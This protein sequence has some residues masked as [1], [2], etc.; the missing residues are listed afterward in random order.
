MS[1]RSPFAG[2]KMTAPLLSLSD[3]SVGYDGTPVASGVS[4]EV[5]A[6]EFV[7]LLGPSGCGK[8]TILRT[9]AGFIKPISGR[10]RLQGTDITNLPPEVRDVGIVFQNYALF[11]NMTAF[12]N[13]AFGLRVRKTPNAEVKTRVHELAEAA[14]LGAHLQ[15]R[16]AELSGGQQQRVAIARSLIMGSKVLLFDEPLSNLDAQVRGAMRREIKRLQADLGFTAIFVTHDQEEALSMSDRIVVLNE[17]RVEQIGSA[18]ALY[19]QPANPFV[20]QFIGSAN[21]LPAR[22][23]K[24]LVGEPVEGNAFVRSEHLV[25]SDTG[26]AANVS[27]VEFLGMHSKVTCQS[28]GVELTAIVFGDRLPAPGDAVKLTADRAALHV[29]PESDT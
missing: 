28:Q 21:A 11:A 12:E 26:L 16:P 10:I 27:H 3:L 13:I 19:A 9:I 8:T 4:L 7:S 1:L 25:F 17:G 29:F 22:L 5:A 2:T 6:G 20:C 15:K 23:A 14:G 18:R 24:D